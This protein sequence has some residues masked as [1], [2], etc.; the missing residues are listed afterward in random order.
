M[1][2]R[3]RTY[4]WRPTSS[5]SHRRHAMRHG[6]VPRVNFAFRDVMRT[7]RSRR[8]PGL[9]DPDL[10]FAVEFG[11]TYRTIGFELS[12]AKV[13]SYRRNVDPTGEVGTDELGTATL[14]EPTTDASARWGCRL[15][16]APGGTSCRS[17]PGLV[18]RH[19]ISVC[20]YDVTHNAETLG[21]HPQ[22]I[23]AL[24]RDG[25]RVRPSGQSGRGRPRVRREPLKTGAVAAGECDR[26]RGSPQ[27][28]RQTY[29]G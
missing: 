21:Y 27:R 23:L 10:P 8:R 1:K 2:P 12:A 18:A 17:A 24:R 16:Q 7:M 14:L 29:L 26:G 3:G 22:D 20:A 15:L 4:P 25:A 19:R 28:V 13:E 6:L 5:A 11:K 9:G